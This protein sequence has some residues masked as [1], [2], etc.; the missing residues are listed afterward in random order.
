MQLLFCTYNTVA[1][2]F[3][4]LFFFLFFLLIQREKERQ[5]N[6][7]WLPPHVPH[8]GTDKTWTLGMCPDREWNQGPFGLVC[9]RRRPTNLATPTRA[10]FTSFFNN[11][12]FKILFF[13]I[14]VLFNYSCLHFLPT[15][16]PTPA[17]PTSLP[18]FHPPPWFCPCV[19]YK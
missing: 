12:F 17:K 14:T 4:T 8:Q 11:V 19:L 10:H 7:H 13:K 15:T 5:R 2:Y 3:F 18:C 6:T 16:P 1:M 9:R